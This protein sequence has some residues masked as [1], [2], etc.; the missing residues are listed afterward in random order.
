VRKEDGLHEENAIEMR[1]SQ[2]YALQIGKL[3]EMRIVEI[4]SILLHEEADSKRVDR[5][6]RRI[7][8]DGYIKNPVIAAKTLRGDFL[9]L[10]GVNRLFAIRA[11]G[12]S[13][14]P[15]QQVDIA[16]P[17]VVLSTWHHVAEGLSPQMMTR[18]IS[19]LERVSEVKPRLS[20]TG[21]LIPDFDGDS[22]CVVYMRSRRCYLIANG[23]SAARRLQSIAMVRELLDK[24]SS[25]DRVSYTNLSDLMSHYPAFSCL[26][27]YRGFSKEEVM[28]LAS[29]GM[30]LPSGVTRF[31][32]PKRA[33]SLCVPLSLLEAGS[34]AEKNKRLEQL[35]KE[36]ISARRIRF[37]EEPTFYFDD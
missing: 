12:L 36:K 16:D 32:V 23:T 26:V 27:C 28:E 20:P 22:A 4:G 31:S 37:Y 10:D 19:R 2:S 5:L 21:D 30:K 11:I 3:P 8:Q 35:I 33:L 25:V 7:L 1:R 24:A 14:I 29:D 15:I 6:K 34:I 13:S 17:K 9:L 18:H